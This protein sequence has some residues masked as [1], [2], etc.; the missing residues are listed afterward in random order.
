RPVG[1]KGDCTVYIRK[2]ENIAEELGKRGI[3]IPARLAV[4]LDTTPYN[5]VKRFAAAFPGSEIVDGSAIMRAARAVKTDFEV[6]QLR[7]C[8]IRHT[9]SY[10]R[11]NKVYR[12][13]M[14]DIELQIEIERILRLEGSLGQFRI[15]GRSMEI[16]MGNLLVGDNAD[17]PTPYDFAMGGAGLSTSLPV[18]SNGT[19]IK[20]GNSV[21]VDMCGNFNGYMTDMTRTFRCG[22]IS[23]LA[24]QAHQL[25]I[26][27]CNTLAANF[28]AGSRAADL[29]NTAMEM[30]VAAHLDDY[31]MGHAQKAGFVGHGVGI[32][33]NEMP[34][35]APRSKDI[36][37]YNN[38]IAIE[39][40]FVI[41][42]VGAV[43]IE[44]TYVVRET[45]LECLTN[46]PEQ[47]SELF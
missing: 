38:V 21:M 18:G 43:G 17:C 39:P 5:E 29:Y 45:H 31:F 9:E 26:D 19:L 41:P 33:V 47:I 24:K 35:L 6:E 34:V 15:S 3:A 23:Y 46:F 13:G 28:H 40:K 27:I 30:A 20:R 7:K 44:N 1:L 12:E 42:E 16:F 14:S 10:H 25:S 32:E 37:Q 2:V 4:E 22:E 8:G 11:I 36:L